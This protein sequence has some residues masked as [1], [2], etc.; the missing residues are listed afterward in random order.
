LLDEQLHQDVAAAL[1]VLRR[2]V[3][4][5]FSHVYDHD[6]GG[7]ADGEIPGFCTAHGIHAITT[8][9]VR[10]FGA[11]KTL[12]VELLDSGIH[13]VVLRFGKA[14]PTIEVQMSALVLAANRVTSILDAAQQPTL[15][16]VGASGDCVGRS[17]EELVT[18]ITGPSAKYP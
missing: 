11:R 4:D 14:Q 5:T 15:V 1:T 7:I 3:G 17:I 13:V 2:S 10:D 12:Y 9:N 8:A 16:R 18:E 6:I